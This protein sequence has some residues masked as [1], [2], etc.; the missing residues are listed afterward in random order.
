MPTEGHAA[1]TAPTSP[2]HVPAY[3]LLAATLF[4]GVA[5]SGVWEMFQ[6]GSTLALDN[7]PHALLDFRKGRTTAA[8]EKQLDQKLPDR[9]TLIAVA[10]SLRYL[11]THAAG[12]QVRIGAQDWLFLNE[13]LQFHEHSPANQ[14]TRI[15]LLNA[16]SRALAQQH[17]T[18]VVAL[19]P[20]KARIEAAYLGSGKIPAYNRLRY[21]AALDDLR[22][23]GVAVVDL[24]SPLGLAAKQAAVYYR[25]DTHWNQA[26]AQLAARTIAAQIRGLNLDLEPTAFR[27]EPS[28]VESERVGD[29]LF[30]M[31][32]DRV[33]NALRPQPDREHITV[34]RQTSTETSGGLFG[35][36]SVPV[37]LT[38][39]SYSLRGNFHGFLQEALGVKILNAAKD[40][41]GFLQATTQYLQDESFRTS[42]PKVLLWEVPERFLGT[43][44]GEEPQWLGSVGLTSANHPAGGKPSDP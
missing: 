33:P 30:L 23:Q 8:I 7:I 31:G 40:G 21:Q 1:M 11:L 3:T 38:G 16:V 15:E 14:K 18:L 24:L 41:A 13:E 36:A 25:S 29:L 5:L 10:N 34:T 39:T 26:G 37:V 12:E 6:A 9:K 28:S 2:T 44:L 22:A 20:D 27:S 17:V 43:P 42:K 32:L 35:D 19:V 4:C